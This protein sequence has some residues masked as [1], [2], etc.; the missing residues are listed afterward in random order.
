MLLTDARKGGVR[1]GS[2]TALETVLGAGLVAVAFVTAGGDAL[3]A[4]TWVEIVLVAIGAGLAAWLVLAGARGPWWGAGAV[5]LFGAVAVDTACSIGWSVTPDQSW[6][7][8]GRTLAYLATFAGAA[9]L[10]RLLPERWRAIVGALAAMAIALALWA[11]FAKVF[12]LAADQQV[13]YGRLLTPFGY[14]NA[15]GLVAAM[16]LP[17]LLWEGGRHDRG[18]VARGLSAPATALLITVIVLSYSRSAVVAGVLGSGVVLFFGRTRLRSVQMLA[19]GGLGAAAICGWALGDHSL[20][21]DLAQGTARGVG[22]AARRSADETFGI[23]V[24]IALLVTAAAGVA[25]AVATER[26]PLTEERRRMIGTALLAGVA[27]IPVA[28]AIALLASSRGFTGE[29][30]HVWSTLTRASGASDTPGRLVDLSNSRPGYWRQGLSVGSHHLLAGAGA[31]SFGIAHLRYGTARLTAPQQVSHAHS[32]AVETFADFGL[33]GLI[34]NL[35]LL[36]AWARAV[37]WT[38]GRP[39]GRADAER[40]AMLALL[41][42]AVAFGVSSAIDWTWFFP[43]VA[44]PALVA[45]GWLAGRGSLARP[46][47]LRSAAGGARTG[48][49]GVGGGARTGGAGVGGGA[50]TGGAGGVG[51]ARVRFGAR[52]ILGAMVI[53]LVA[54][55]LGYLT[56]QPLHSANADA[57]AITA[58]GSD[59]AAAL[60]DARSAVNDFPVS[61]QAIETLAGLEQAAHDDAAAE[62]ELWHGTSVQPENPNAWEALGLFDLQH[63]HWDEALIVLRRAAALDVTDWT[64]PLLQAMIVDAENRN[65]G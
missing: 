42:V 18:V 3:G 16:G 9:V 47:G 8:A 60:T 23:V 55:A 51:G 24:V 21:G 17:A 49:A 27:L 46:V 34:L 39:G 38:V 52:S 33:I 59:V 43:G 48:D 50:R 64:N 12:T 53:G 13:D 19:L 15:T 11:V 57:A 28:V 44:V 14:W 56:W 37:R 7:E 45:A 22:L 35:A 1:L 58:E 10:A 6:I 25:A 40:D 4:N 63:K 2:D 29:I 31:G 62:A 5:A 65:F 61:L 26:R 54:L 32:Y 36:V 20:T 41:G 30:S